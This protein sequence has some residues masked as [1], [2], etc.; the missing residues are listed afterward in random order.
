MSE[1]KG[2]EESS[3]KKQVFCHRMRRACAHRRAIDFQVAEGNPSK[4]REGRGALSVVLK[5]GARED[6]FVR[7]KSGCSKQV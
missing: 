6:K 1:T 5:A 4:A 2:F 3:S 7:N